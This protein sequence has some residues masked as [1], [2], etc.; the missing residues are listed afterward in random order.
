[1]KRKLFFGAAFL[2][3]AWAATYCTD[4]GDCQFCKIVER[5]SGGTL[6]N[7]GTEAEYCGDDID[8]YIAANPPVTNPSTGNVTQVEC[9]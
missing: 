7:S 1:M 3:I 8:A 9:D 5:T 2:F 6:V 4:L